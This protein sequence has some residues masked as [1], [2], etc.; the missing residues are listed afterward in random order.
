MANGLRATLADTSAV[1]DRDAHRLARSLAH[2]AFT[3]RFQREAIDHYLAAADRACAAADRH[4][5]RL[6]G[7]DTAVSI[8]DGRLALSPLLRA[9]EQAGDAGPRT[10]TLASALAVACRY[11]GGDGLASVRA[12]IAQLLE[13][14][15]GGSAATARANAGPASVRTAA[16]LATPRLPRALRIA[17][18]SGRSRVTSLRLHRSRSRP[19][20]AACAGDQAGFRPHA[21]RSLSVLVDH[22][23]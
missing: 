19:G 4:Q 15:S 1:P 16:L 21:V 20:G 11:L 18:S 3:R 10:A 14:A 5:D 2:L 6:N 22:G 9:A 7:A 8:A 12:H 23:A 13:A 17:C